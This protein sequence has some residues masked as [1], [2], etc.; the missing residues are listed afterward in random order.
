MQELGEEI[1]N[2]RRLECRRMYVKPFSNP[3]LMLKPENM[4]RTHYAHTFPHLFG[5]KNAAT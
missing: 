1:F 4:R 3:L 2:E 5:R